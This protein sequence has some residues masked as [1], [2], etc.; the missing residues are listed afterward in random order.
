MADV[1]LSQRDI[2][3]ISRVVDTEVPRSLARRNPQEYKRMVDAVVDTV[4]NRMASGEFPATATGV[5]NQNRQFSKITG[6]KALDPYGSVEN[7]PRAPAEVRNM[8]S[9]R[10][11]GAVQGEPSLIGGALNY[12]NPNFSSASNRRS[13]IDPMID[14]GARM[15]GLG[16]NVHYHGTA[17]GMEPVGPYS[18]TAEGIPSG[19]IPTPVSRDAMP[20]A[21]AGYGLM[22]TI[23]PVTPGAVER[24]GLLADP[25]SLSSLNYP[26]SA[27]TIGD[28]SLKGQ[29]AFDMGRFGPSPAQTAGFD[30]GRFG[31]AP[32]AMPSTATAFDAERFGPQAPVA[33]SMN[34]LRRGLLDQQLEA[35]ILPSLN[36]PAYTELAK[37]VDPMTTAATPGYVDPMV[38]TGVQPNAPAVQAPAAISPAS[39]VASP[40]EQ[41]LADA[42]GIFSS[43]P[44]YNLARRV[45]KQMS[46]RKMTGGLLGGLLGGL[47]LGPLGALGGGLLGRSVAQRTY[48]PEAP[49]PPSS[50]TANKGGGT[51]YN[52]LSDYGRDV[53]S[54]SDQFSD[55]VSS[56]RGG[57]W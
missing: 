37:P 49:K 51:G 39:G 48:H 55:A 23:D 57:L 8:V 24:G 2:D 42:G 6:P 31:P 53:H 45:D 33:A 44:D 12:A 32:E 15:F 16:Q 50:K 38:T 14:A 17:P 56:G 19:N 3:Y 13:W 20:Q 29:K 4:T 30:M 47:A 41:A 43:T 10:I 21:Q 34:D 46:N 11:A 52:S 22:S 18:V 1:N 28:P 9:E 27:P 35:G 40:E 5:L 36:Q 26:S 25:R 54:K 7:T